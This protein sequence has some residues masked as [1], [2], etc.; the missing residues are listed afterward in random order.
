MAAQMDNVSLADFGNVT[1][2]DLEDEAMPA[3]AL[4]PSAVVSATGK[5]SCRGG[6][7]PVPQ[8][9]SF[10]PAISTEVWYCNTGVGVSVDGAR[11]ALD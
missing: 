1:L 6:S 10:Y 5:V 3:V 2:E 9:L 8:S 4:R 11:L 7:R